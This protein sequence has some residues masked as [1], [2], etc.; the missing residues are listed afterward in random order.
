MI[1]W[2]KDVDGNTGLWDCP[3]FLVML[4]PLPEEGVAPNVDQLFDLLLS[5]TLQRVSLAQ[6]KGRREQLGLLRCAIFCH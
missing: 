3:A 2:H 4:K 6:K 5:V 1:W